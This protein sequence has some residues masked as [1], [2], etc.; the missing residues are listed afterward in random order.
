MSEVKAEQKTQ[1]VKVSGT[2]WLCAIHEGEW[3]AVLKLTD[4]QIREWNDYI[5]AMT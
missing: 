2:G 3:L 5:K 1:R 4:E